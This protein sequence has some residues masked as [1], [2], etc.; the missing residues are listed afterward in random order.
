MKQK[1][2]VKKLM[3][4]ISR[5]NPIVLGNEQRE[6]FTVLSIYEAK[7][8][9][10]SFC[11]AKTK[12]ALTTIRNSKASIIICAKGIEFKPEDYEDKTLI[13][14]RNPPLV[15]IRLMKAYFQKEKV[16]SG[17][18][19]T[20]VIDEKASIHPSVYIGPHSYIGESEV[21][22]GTIIHGNVH[23]YS[24]V[25]IGKNVLIHAG[26][27]I[28]ADGFGYERNEKG[29]FEKFPHIGGII[30]EDDVEIGSNTS[31]DRGTLGNTVIGKG[32][33]V[34]NLCHIAHNVIIGKNCAIIAHTILGG[35][36]KIGD[37]SWIAPTV[38]VR[39][40]IKIGK[41]VLVGM[42]AVV[43]KNVKDNAVVF[44]APAK[45]ADEYKKLLKVFRK[46][47]KTQ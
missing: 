27:V 10:L 36:V 40:G 9:S 24:G 11:R 26:T 25:K 13:L 1:M 18:H 8:G 31:I 37:G 30:I 23:I 39:E 35:S 34:D 21:D 16:E 2:T 29:E 4:S 41:N 44:G 45:P 19:P 38:S 42:A 5:Y 47:I 28:G 46:L 32:T 22:E 15:F 33:K 12:D 17:I 3:E 43:T 7:S 14:V 6:F 20:A